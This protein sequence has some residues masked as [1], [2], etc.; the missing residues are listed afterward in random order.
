MRRRLR[1][2]VERVFAG[3]ALAGAL[4]SATLGAAMLAGCKDPTHENEHENDGV[5]LARLSAASLPLPHPGLSAPRAR[6]A[7]TSALA[8][9][10]RLI[11]DQPATLPYATTFPS[12]GG[13]LVVTVSGAAHRRA[14]TP[15]DQ[16][17][18]EVAI[19]GEI[20]GSLPGVLHARAVPA[21]GDHAAHP[22]ATFVVDGVA[23]GEHA[24]TIRGHEG[25]VTT[26]H[27]AFTVTVAELR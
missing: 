13:K 1:F 7:R 4:S 8:T 20:I 25:T 18:A 11:S 6:P 9:V 21:A 16:A 23:P 2:Q 10:T 15:A 24:I 14:D 22:A 26:S 3:A 17:S 12:A 27:D 19:D 5:G